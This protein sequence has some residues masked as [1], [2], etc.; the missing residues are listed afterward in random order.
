MATYVLGDIH[1]EFK[2]MVQMLS[3]VG[4]LVQDDSKGWVWRK[5]CKDTLIQVGD[6]IDGAPSTQCVASFRFLRGLQEQ[7]D[8]VG[9]KVIR[10]LGNHELAYISPLKCTGM[11]NITDIALTDIIKQD[12]IDKKIQACYIW[13]KHIISHAGFSINTI[14]EYRLF[15]DTMINN[16][17]ICSVKKQ[18]FRDIIFNIGKSRG[19]LSDTPGIFWA[20]WREDELV[21]IKQ[22]VGHTSMGDII[23]DD[24]HIN[25][26]CGF[27]R[28]AQGVASILKYDK[29]K[30]KIIYLEEDEEKRNMSSLCKDLMKYLDEEWNL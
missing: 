19:G 3:K 11:D 8:E 10:L 24:N 13:N 5:D 6:M 7:A 30:F 15:T 14:G 17:L 12:V 2:L 21:N 9:G 22:I 28:R 1:G 26:D 25:V 29:D 18:D 27:S 23:I 16:A 4:L 20:D